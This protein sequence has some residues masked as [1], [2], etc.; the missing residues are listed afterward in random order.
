[1]KEYIEREAL[2]KFLTDQKDKETGAYSK[3]RNAGLDVARSALHNREITPAADVAPVV[4]CKN[5]RNCAH[6]KIFG[7]YWCNR[8]T[9]TYKVKPDDFCS[10]GERKDIEK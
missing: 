6:D 5:C 4:L 7:N 3:G 8:M 10:Y 2:Y 9:A 1:M